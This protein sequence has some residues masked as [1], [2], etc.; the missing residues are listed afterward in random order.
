ML[1][2]YA[3]LMLAPY[4]DTLDWRM[5]AEGI[6][7]CGEQMQ[8]S[9]GESIGT[10]PDVFNLREQSR[11]PADINPGALVSLRLLLRLTFGFAEFE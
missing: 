10:L 7:I 3:L 11:H 1:S 6:T 5:V 2:A 8:Y 4:D 9:D